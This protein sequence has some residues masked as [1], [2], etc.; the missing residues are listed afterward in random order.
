MSWIQYFVGVSHFAECREK[1]A[2]D[3]MRDAKKSP[4]ILY[5]A[6]VGK[7]ERGRYKRDNDFICSSML[8][9]L[10]THNFYI[11]MILLTNNFIW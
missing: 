6:T 2:G 10:L 11:K 1:A 9:V 8:A 4:K 3:C 5:S 7:V